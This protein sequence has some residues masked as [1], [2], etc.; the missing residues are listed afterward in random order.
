MSKNVEGGENMEKVEKQE[1]QKCPSCDETI[2]AK[3][4]RCPH[5][6]HDLRN[7][8]QRHP[9]L[10]F[11]IIIFFLV[12]VLSSASQNPGSQNGKSTTP[13]PERKDTFMASVN[14]TGTEF[15][16]SN[17]DK[18]PCQN[19]RMKVNGQYTLEGYNLESALDST[20]KTGTA[21]V[22]RVGAGQFVKGDGSRF[23]PFTT[24]PLDFNIYCRG[25]NE[26]TSATWYGEF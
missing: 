2:S 1:T 4:K 14:F 9:I 22:Y 20:V 24:K 23:N 25:N 26:L 7:W 12:S 18:S 19:A 6:R 5:C 3:A 15:V 13:K 11:F 8:F 16:I 10:T 17:L 21:T